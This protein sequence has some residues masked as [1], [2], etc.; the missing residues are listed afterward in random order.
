MVRGLSLIAILL[1]APVEEL[2]EGPFRV[3]VHESNRQN[4]ISRQEVS[5]IFMKRMRSWPAGGE[6]LPA[7]PRTPLR[8]QFARQVHGKSLAYVTRYWQRLIFAGRG[9]PPAQFPSEEDVV[10]YVASNPGAI[11]YIG[12]A[13]AEPD[14]VRVITVRP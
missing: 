11:G 7:E 4:S 5:A 6:I 1:L 12:A 13:T 14:G 3:I 8:E 9:I 10:A 2:A